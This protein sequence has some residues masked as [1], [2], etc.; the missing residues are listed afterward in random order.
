VQPQGSPDL[1]RSLHFLLPNQTIQIIM[2]VNVDIAEGGGGAMAISGG[3]NYYR[4]SR[5][6]RVSVV[7]QQR[8]Q[9]E[10]R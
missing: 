8:N 2:P 4:F 9:T 10:M 3:W 5:R 7:A 6:W 1:Q